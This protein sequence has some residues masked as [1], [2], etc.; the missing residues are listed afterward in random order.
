[1]EKSVNVGLHFYMQFR[2]PNLTT[3]ATLS[4]TFVLAMYIE[5][6]IKN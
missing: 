5:A 2:F 1:M 6:F 4:D 3:D